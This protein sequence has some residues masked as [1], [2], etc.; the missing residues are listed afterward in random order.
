MKPMPAHPPS[1]GEF[2]F[3]LG[4]LLAQVVGLVVIFGYLFAMAWR[5]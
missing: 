5:M 1:S 3:V 4:G 2:Y